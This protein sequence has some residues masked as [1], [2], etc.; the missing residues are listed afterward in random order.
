MRDA[1]ERLFTFYFTTAR[2]REAAK[3]F[4]GLEP[5]DEHQEFAQNEIPAS[6]V[7]VFAMEDGMNVQGA[8]GFLRETDAVIADA[9]A[10]LT[11]FSLELF[12]ISFAGLRK[13][14]ERGKDTHGS[15]SI[16][17]ANVS[18]RVLGPGDLS[19]T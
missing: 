3:T 2:K 7:G 11:G 8:A 1:L 4:V 10:Q 6:A 5:R 17:A 13:P 18:A 16:Q 14:A 9:E 19:H 12:Y 15:V